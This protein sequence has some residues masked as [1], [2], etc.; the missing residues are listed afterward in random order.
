MLRKK[1][2]IIFENPEPVKPDEQ[3]ATALYILLTIAM[4]AKKLLIFLVLLSSSSLF[5]LW[6]SQDN[7]TSNMELFETRP[8]QLEQ[9]LEVT[10]QT[11]I[12]FE[13][14]NQIKIQINTQINKRKLKVIEY[15]R[16]RGSKTSQIP[17]YLIVNEKY[18]LVFCPIPKSGCTT[19]IATL[20][21]LDGVDPIHFQGRVWQYIYERGI[22][23]IR[24]Y[25]RKRQE[26]ILRDYY[27]VM[28]VR[29]PLE[30]LLSA[31]KDKFIP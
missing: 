13:I 26:E 20:F 14:T 17:H 21:M 6:M 11:K 9:P 7:T 30:R 31:Y 8:R 5:F 19:F 3:A 16:K 2:T 25:N 27:K 12:K 29:D 28:I 24:H 1:E 23:Y 18:K 15:C 10:N 22:R 4:K